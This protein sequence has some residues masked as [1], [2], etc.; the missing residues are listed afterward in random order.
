[1]HILLQENLFDAPQKS[2]DILFELNVND[3]AVHTWNDKKKNS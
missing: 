3:T 2:M 1:M